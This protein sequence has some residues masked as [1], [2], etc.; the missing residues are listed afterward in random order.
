MRKKN[1]QLSWVIGKIKHRIPMLGLLVLSSMG[2]AFCSVYFALGT[3]GV[4]DA[5]VAGERALFNKA[6]LTQLG[7][8]IG[9]VLCNL[10]TRHLREHLNAELDRDWKKALLHNLLNSEFS[11][12]S[13][14]HSSE[15]VNRLNNDV[16]TLD[17]A[18]VNLLPQLASMLTRLICALGF[19]V[20]MSPWFTAILLV[21]GVAVVFI[22]GFLRRRLKGLHKRV[23]EANGRVS[24]ILQETLEKLLV[25][26]AMD[27][28]EEI[29]NRTKVRLDERFTI[30]RK[31]KNISLI[32][33]TCTNVLFLAAGFVSLIWCASGLLAGTMDFGTMT[34]ITQL[35]N[36]LQNPFVNLSGVIP[37]YIAACAAVDRL[38]EIAQLPRTAELCEE[39]ATDL[40]ARMDGIVG[41]DLGFA[42]DRDPILDSA[43]FQL[44]KG[45][46]CAIT[47]PSGIGKST[48]L[49]L[50]LGIYTPQSGRLYL[51]CGSEKI[52]VNR[53]TRHLFNYVPQG[54]LLFSGTIRENLLVAKPDATN[55]EINKALYVS[56]MDAYLSQLPAGLDTV[57]GESGAGL[58]EGQAQR[59]AIARAILGGAP[60]ILLDECTSALDNHTEKLI[61]QRLNELEDKTFIAVTHR[62]AAEE[63]CD[64]KLVMGEGKVRMLMVKER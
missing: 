11:A 50:L 10:L 19:L 36:Q 28:S 38:Y 42:Y 43:D 27:I 5:A 4:I 18:I 22:T 14:Y 25:V 31:R 6:C 57:L 49:K 59:L 12:V 62:P 51:Q 47:G 37:Q 21:A 64:C 58:S 46:F 40:Y 30:V 26:Q 52:P 33:N 32:S 39:S 3:K 9:I 35:V 56:T 17:G 44:A 20:F 60:I 63:I 55:D 7:I 41:E 29:E 34:A 16:I 2:S 48:I 45:D 13:H 1:T 15:L 8:I 24:G 23:S 61:L 54:N 53:S